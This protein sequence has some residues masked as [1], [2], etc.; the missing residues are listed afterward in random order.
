MLFKTAGGKFI[1]TVTIPE[2]D[3]LTICV[4]SQV[5]CRMNCDFA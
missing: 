3:R 1:E 2:E 4:S 5:G